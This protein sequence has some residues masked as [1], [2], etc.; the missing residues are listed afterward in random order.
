[1]TQSDYLNLALALALGLLVGLQREWVR[2]RLAGIRTYPMIAVLGALCGILAAHFGN[3]LPVAGF[4][5][6][7][8]LALANGRLEPKEDVVEP[9]EARPA[10]NAGITTE[11]SILMMFA[12]G[13]LLATDNRLAAICLTGV[14]TVLLHW[15][16]LLH[17]WVHRIEEGELRAI[18]RLA[19]IGMVILPLMP[20]RDMGPFGVFNPFKMWL[21]VVLIVGLSLGAYV[22]KRV[23]GPRSGSLAAG[24][25]GGLISSTATTVSSAQHS[26]SS[27]ESVTVAAGAALVIMV[28]STI[29]FGRVMVELMVVAPGQLRNL[30]PPLAVMMLWMLVISLFLL[31]RPHQADPPG[32]EKKGPPA[33]GLKT[34]LWFGALYALVLLAVTA[35]EEYLDHRWLYAVAA[36]SGLTDM[37]AITLS[38]GQLVES[39][40]IDP[41]KGWRLILVGGMANLVFKGGMV[42]VLGSRI[43]LKRIAILF[44]AGLAGGVLLL[45]AWPG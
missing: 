32:K 15:K 30:A 8:A 40:Q 43:L 6:I 23:L 37:D 38:T 16:G 20:N 22:A 13:L 17:R 14:M 9:G 19:L 7:G 21:M 24:A 11:V 41:A 4:L 45:V 36:L 5:A 27:P 35:A 10:T 44:A 3:W 26:K 2:T 42:A 12:I 34:A 31:L 39:G 1:L 18:I 33:S 29:V 25:L 28:A